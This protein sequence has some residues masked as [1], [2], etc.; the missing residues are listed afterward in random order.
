M[1]QLASIIVFS[2]VFLLSYGFVSVNQPYR[3]QLHSFVTS[4]DTELSDLRLT[5]ELEKYVVRFRNVPDDKLRYQQLFFL[6]SKCNPMEE[7]FKIDQ[8]KVLFRDT[9]IAIV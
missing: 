1:A 9:L 4:V 5:P 8:N 6:A 2:S 3:K 7:A